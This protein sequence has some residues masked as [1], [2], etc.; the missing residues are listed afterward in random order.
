[1][2]PDLFGPSQGDP[3]AALFGMN[4]P[5]GPGPPPSSFLPPINAHQ[6]Q[7]INPQQ[8][9]LMMTKMHMQIM[10]QLMVM[11]SFMTQ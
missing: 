7:Q 4:T 9:S 1:M 11:N 8:M 3:M 10:Q 2:S 6:Q 5:G